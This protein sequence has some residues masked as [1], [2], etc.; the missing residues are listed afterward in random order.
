MR[1]S[2]LGKAF[3]LLWIAL[4][5]VLACGPVRAG[6]RFERVRAA[7]LTLNV[8]TADLGQPEVRVVTAAARRFP[9]SAESFGSLIARAQPTA[10]INGTYFG[11]RN[12]CLVGDLV[13]EGRPIYLGRLGTAL[14]LTDEGQAKFVDM[15]V[16][17][18]TGWR[19]YRSVVCAGPR[20]I[21]EGQQI[22]SP[23]EEGFSDPHVLG[24]ARRSALGVTLENRLLLVTTAGAA[25]LTQLARAMSALGA[26][27]AINLDGGTSS[28]LYYRGRAITAPGRRLT[29]WILV[30]DSPQRLARVRHRLVPTGYSGMPDRS[31][32]FRLSAGGLSLSGI[33]DG[34]T[35]GGRVY[36]LIG[37]TRQRG[38]RWAVIF[39]D[40]ASRCIVNTFPQQ[41]AWDTSELADGPHALTAELYDANG[42]L[43]A[44]Q[45]LRV[46]VRNRPLPAE[47][48]PE[49]T[50]PPSVGGKA[51][52]AASAE[53]GP[54][55]G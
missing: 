10:A 43:A 55:R 14:A 2:S 19:G 38:A 12:L 35:I 39:V 21:M 37:L 20:L 45:A 53:T 31:K 42:R 54:G 44:K 36:V 22:V 33:R 51:S 28:A 1:G 27:W 46:R 4:V 5:A 13:V 30:Y 7:G 47:P 34:S 41:F 25:T 18:Q 26:H 6:V 3:C 48:M 17:R 29:N 32:S 52:E 9:Y 24:R 15:Q 11:Q 50:L 23:R 8:V 16:G 40:G 49:I